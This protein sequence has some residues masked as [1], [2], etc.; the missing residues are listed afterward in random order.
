MKIYLARNNVQAGPYTLDELNTMLASGEVL[1]DDLAWHSGMSAWQRLGD[2]THNQLM[3]QPNHT[4]PNHQRSFGDNVEFYPPNQDTE[5]KV[6]VD[7][8]YGRTIS[9]QTQSVVLKDAPATLSYAS[10]FARFVA[11]G[12]NLSLYLLALLPALTAFAQVVDVNQLASFS[13]YASVQAYAQT[14]AKQVNQTTVNTSSLMLFALFAIQL[15][16]IMM[17]GQSFG[18]MVVGIRVLDQTTHKLPSLGV[19]L[20][21]RTVLLIAIYSVALSFFSGLPAIALLAINYLLANGNPH[22]QGWHDK[23]AKTI[24]V[25][26]HPAQLDKTKS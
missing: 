25:K 1:L 23:M 22:K 17:R 20:L 7:E 4:P 19:L 3:Y 14:L 18:K 10:I 13:D 15:L 6:S 24:V 8:L 21:M 11:F 16:L 9:T 26:A 5:R 12:I 2:L